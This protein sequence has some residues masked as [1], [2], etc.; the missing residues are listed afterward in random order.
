MVV[1]AKLADLLDVALAR[2]TAFGATSGDR[3]DA[4]AILALI[5]ADTRTAREAPDFAARLG[6]DQAR[7]AEIVGMLEAV[8]MVATVRRGRKH[9]L[10]I[11]PPGDPMPPLPSADAPPGVSANAHAGGTAI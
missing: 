5:A 6:L 2:L 10:A 9:R 4:V 11:I 3:R 7:W 1:T 8:G